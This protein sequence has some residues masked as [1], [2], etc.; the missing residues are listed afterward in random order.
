MMSWQEILG[1]EAIVERFRRCVQRGRL[2]STFLFIGPAGIGKFRFAQKMA[3]AL[4]CE[5]YS[6]HELES[7]GKCP[8]CRQ[9]HNESHPDLEIVRKPDDK[10]FIPLEK[11]VGDKE[12]G[13][14]EGLCQRMSLKPFCGGRKIAI[15]DDADFLNLEGANCLLKTLEEPPPRSVLF[16]IG[17][18]EYKQLPTIRSRC[19][20]IRFGAL[21]TSAVQQLLLKQGLVEDP[22]QA[23][24]LAQQS[25]GSL[26]RALEYADPDLYEIRT[27]LFDFLAQRHPDSV[28]L[29]RLLTDF[30]DDVGQD[31]PRKRQRMRQVI[32]SGAEFYS[33]LIRLMTGVQLGEQHKSLEET[34]QRALHEGDGEETRV[35]QKLERCLLAVDQLQANANVST[36]LE[37]WVDDLAH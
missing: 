10:S 22:N 30:L 11:F 20:V 25:E 5:E 1:H 37:C 27:Q 34:V 9:V 13:T 29:S 14:R 36:L 31:V 26:K 16:L 23:A 19:Q 28:A 24:E 35:A 21:P 4:L 2:A 3:A 17:T 33:S 8:A 12:H 15:I 6:E 32:L 7:C 18:S